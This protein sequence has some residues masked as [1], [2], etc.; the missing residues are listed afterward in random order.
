MTD[1]H[2]ELAAALLDLRDIGS[3][4]F[5]FLSMQTW[6]TLWSVLINILSGGFWCMLLKVERVQAK[7]V[8]VLL[9]ADDVG[10]CH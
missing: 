1:A 9:H 10:L 7:I 4:I 8:A 3:S 2:R 6:L 5:W